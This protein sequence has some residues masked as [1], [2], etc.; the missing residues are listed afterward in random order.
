MP[1]HRDLGLLSFLPSLAVMQSL[2]L[3]PGLLPG[4]SIC[5]FSMDDETR[6]INRATWTKNL[7]FNI[8]E[9]RGPLVFIFKFFPV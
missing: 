2:L 6:K 8:L 9:I 7:A 3:Q 1:T 4:V 5:Q